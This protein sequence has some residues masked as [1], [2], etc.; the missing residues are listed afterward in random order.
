[1]VELIKKLCRDRDISIKD[2]E[3]ETGI[4]TNS[5][6][7]WDKT[8]P[9]VNSVALVARY[10][11][12]SVDFL[13]GMEESAMP[14][15]EQRLTANFRLLDDSQKQAVFALMN[16]FLSQPVSKDAKIS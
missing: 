9:S 15:D 4:G 12:V 11:D 14:D 10:F 1:M 7:K 8:S 6:Y 5:I 16:G 2:L 3:R 13:I